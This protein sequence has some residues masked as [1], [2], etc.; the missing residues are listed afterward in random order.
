MGNPIYLNT[1]QSFDDLY[2]FRQF[3]RS[4]TFWYRLVRISYWALEIRHRF[5]MSAFCIKKDSDNAEFPAAVFNHYNYISGF[6]FNFHCAEIH[7]EL[8]F[9]ICL[10]YSE[11]A[12]AV[13]A[14]A[15]SPPRFRGQSHLGFSLN[16]LNACF[17]PYFFRQD[18]FISIYA[19]LSHFSFSLSFP[20]FRT[21]LYS[22]I[23]SL[24]G[25][26]SGYSSDFSTVNGHELNHSSPCPHGNP[27]TP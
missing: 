16:L 7:S 26:H 17:L 27:L 5:K 21:I 22:P 23:F 19:V 20:S 15:S 1:G 12:G 11:K 24:N 14:S 2:W 25:H 8:S 18:T 4:R 6:I 9:L 3:C 13:F 10:K